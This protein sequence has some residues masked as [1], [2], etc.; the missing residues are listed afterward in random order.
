MTKIKE[1]EKFRVSISTSE[2]FAL[3]DIMDS[4][5]RGDQLSGLDPTLLNCYEKLNVQ[6]FKIG[7]GIARPAYVNT[8]VKKQSAINLE[9]LGSSAEEVASFEGKYNNSS[10]MDDATNAQLM[11]MVEHPEV[12][13]SNMPAIEE[14]MQGGKYYAGTEQTACDV[15]TDNGDSI[16]RLGLGSV[17]KQSG[18]RNEDTGN[19]GTNTSDCFIDTSDTVSNDAGLAAAIFN[20][21]DSSHIGE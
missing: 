18:E 7:K 5:R 8:G 6:A 21:L 11:W 3:L 12:S 1:L 13:M 17:S 9:A 4:A 15:Q 14:F 20:S 19:V 10:H 16:G 2:I